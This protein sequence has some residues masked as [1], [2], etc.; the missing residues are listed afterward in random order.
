MKTIGT[1]SD[2]VEFYYEREELKPCKKDAGWILK[3]KETVIILPESNEIIPTGVRVKIPKGYVGI[4]K[5]GDWFR[6]IG[7]DTAKHIIGSDCQE[8]IKVAVHNLAGVHTEV[9]KGDEIAQIIFVPVLL[10]AE[11]KEI[12]ETGDISF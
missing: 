6:V 8:E 9:E 10:E 5:S 7:V 2:K 1:C 11:Y 4:I 3:A 12:P